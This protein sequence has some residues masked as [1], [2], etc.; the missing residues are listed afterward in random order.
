MSIDSKQT[1]HLAFWSR[2]VV[3]V[4]QFFANLLIPDHDADAFKSPKHPG[5]GNTFFQHVVE[6]AFGGLRR[7]DAEYFMH[8]AEHGY[9]YENTL[10]FYP[11]FPLTVRYATLIIQSILPFQCAFRELSLL[12]AIALNVVFFILAANA[13]FELTI[14]LMPNKRLGRIVVVLFCIN[15]ASI[16]F[17]APYSESLFCWLS[18]SVMLN[19]AKYRFLRAAIPLVF[20]IWCRSNGSINLGFVFYYMLLKAINS[21]RK[22]TNLLLC[23]PKATFYTTIAIIAFGLVQIYYNL[24][25]CSN[26]THHVNDY[27]RNY[28]KVHDLNVLGQTRKTV[29]CSFRI[30]ISYSY[31]QAQYWNVGFLN[32][33]EP[34]QIPNFLLAAPILIFILYDSIRFAMRSVKL[35]PFGVNWPF[36]HENSW[37]FVYIFHSFVLC[38]FC[39]FFVH[40]QVS[41]R[42]LASSSPCLYWI[43]AQYFYKENSQNHVV[44][45][46]KPKSHMTK[47]IRTWFIAYIIIGTTLFSNFLPWT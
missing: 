4:L 11:L 18:F 42:M 15:P 3:I 25:Y 36:W 27:V 23:I 20:G 5:E 30:P 40:I 29:W 12:V 13:L 34:K 16:F 28:G 47:F 8:I 22:I 10:V 41:T 21:Q 17:T 31:L 32:Y 43:S 7:W 2:L 24:L 39:I 14:H 6:Y 35:L 37:R 9:T 19:C 26:H 33:Y 46:S 45:L 44:M 1:T 38:I